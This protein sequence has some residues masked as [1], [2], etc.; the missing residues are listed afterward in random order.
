[1]Y[2]TDIVIYFQERIMRAES[3]IVNLEIP[4]ELAYVYNKL[5]DWN[6]SHN[7]RH[8]ISV[9]GDVIP[10]DMRYK[11]PNDINSYAFSKYT[12]VY[13]KVS[14]WLSFDRILKLYDVLSESVFVGCLVYWPCH[15][16]TCFCHMQTAKVQISLRIHTV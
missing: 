9:V 8:I 11:L 3:N 5:D 13:F 4:G 14:L 12:S 7:D 1:M 2:G 10:M 15:E 6:P 16:K